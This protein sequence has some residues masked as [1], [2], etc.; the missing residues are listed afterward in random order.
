MKNIT[1]KS[2]SGS[3]KVIFTN[4][5]KF[6]EKESK[7]FLLVDQT[8]FNL[9]KRYLKFN[10]IIYIKANE[11]A[12]SLEFAKKIYLDLLSKNFTKKDQ[13]IAIGGGITQDLAGFVASTIF[14]GVKW[15]YA[16]TTL[17]AQTDSCIG[18]KTSINLKG[19][20]N[21]IGTIFPPEKV[22]I[23][24]AFLK[25]LDEDK[26]KSKRYIKYTRNEKFI[27]LV[28]LNGQIIKEEDARISI[29]D[30]SYQFGYGL[31]ETIL[32]KDGI[33]LFIESHYRRLS[34]SAS[35]IGMLFPIDLKNWIKDVLE[36][37]KLT[38]ARIKIIVSKK[39]EEKFNVLIIASR[40]EPLPSS[41]ALLCKKLSRDPNSVSF[42]NK[43][44]SRADSF[45]AYKKA[46]ENG[47]NDALYLNEKN[48]LVECTRANIFLVIEEKI[49][50]PLLGSGILSGV[51]RSN[52]IEMVKKDGVQIEE[53]NIHSLFLNKA[54]SVFITNAIIGIMPVSKIKTEDKEYSFSTNKLVTRLKNSY[55]AEIQEYIS[56]CH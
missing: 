8:I 27:M 23:S 1:I 53:K 56:S 37:N 19:F 43:T 46:I 41:Y 28:F 50:T 54:Q 18:G 44:T 30:L 4:D 14:R 31:F 52:L 29:S 22:I 12:K 6:L 45:V 16:P 26:I 20:K 42:R 32:C 51:T 3:Y 9:Y 11:S 33:P 34:H 48:E 5:L 17:L 40:Q 38:G 47:F 10:N 35:D 39:L 24:N 49:I 36:A 21:I 15:I 2:R 13:I 25:T 7:S 55:D